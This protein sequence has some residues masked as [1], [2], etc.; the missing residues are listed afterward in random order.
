MLLRLLCALMNCLGLIPGEMLLHL[1]CALMKCLGL[2]PGEMLLR[3]QCALTE[4]LDLIQHL[5]FSEG[6]M[7]SMSTMILLS[8][9]HSHVDCQEKFCR[10]RKTFLGRKAIVRSR[11]ICNYLIVQTICY[12]TWLY[13]MF[14]ISIN[15]LSMRILWFI[16]L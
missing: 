10:K 9:I 3:L 6:L 16:I 2:I 1:L 12:A 8:L 4:N 14:V 5:L 15:V 7:H 13:Y 11:K